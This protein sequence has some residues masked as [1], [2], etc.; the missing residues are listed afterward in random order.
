[1]WAVFEENILLLKVYFETI[2]IPKNAKMLII[3]LFLYMQH[4][5]KQR[6]AEIGK[7][8]RKW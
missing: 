1:M 4:F 2:T 5:Y 3:L 7:R 6:Q 8:S